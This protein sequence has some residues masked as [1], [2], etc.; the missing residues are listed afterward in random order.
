MGLVRYV[1]R[2]IEA[3]LEAAVAKAGGDAALTAVLGKVLSRPELVERAY[4]EGETFLV[5]AALFMAGVR[6]D[7]S[8]YEGVGTIWKED[9]GQR[10]YDPRLST[11]ARTRASAARSSSPSIPRTRSA[12]AW[13]MLEWTLNRGDLR[14][15]RSSAVTSSRVSPESTRQTR[16][17]RVPRLE[18]LAESMAQWAF[19]VRSVQLADTW[20]PR[21]TN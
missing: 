15:P 12:I 4:G 19:P 14:V 9:L 6:L 2:R 21:I 5:K 7:R 13:S 3:R 11:W 16:L 8:A 1:Q 18:A 17:S 20:S 10:H